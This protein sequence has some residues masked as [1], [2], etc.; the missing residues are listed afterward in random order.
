MTPST[1]TPIAVDAVARSASEAADIVDIAGGYFAEKRADGFAIRHERGGLH[2]ALPPEI[3]MVNAI[4]ALRAELK[5]LDALKADIANALTDL[6]DY[7]IENEALRA[8]VAELESADT[9]GRVCEG[10]AYRLEARSLRAKVDELQADNTSLLALVADIR[11]AL[12]DNGKRMQTELIE[13]CA[14]LVKAR[15]E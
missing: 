10:T 11:C 13:W 9:C 15:K 8:R 4:A 3:A 1:R 7:S 5:E 6:T 12:G 14:E 2:M